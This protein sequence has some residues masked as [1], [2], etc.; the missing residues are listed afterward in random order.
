MLGG[1]LQW[2]HYCRLHTLGLNPLL[3]A[4]TVAGYITRYT[5]KQLMPSLLPLRFK[6]KFNLL[7]LL[8]GLIRAKHKSPCD[9][10]GNAFAAVIPFLD[11]ASIMHSLR[12]IISYE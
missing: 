12:L 5:C 8:R 1:W 11:E 4:S 3:A 2:L 10:L 6:I 7:L 9:Q